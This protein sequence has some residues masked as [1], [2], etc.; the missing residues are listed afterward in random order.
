MAAGS[1][2]AT[3]SIIVV[4]PQTKEV[5]IASATCLLGL[6]LRSRTP[7]VVVE[8][9]AGVGQS[10]GDATNINR[11]FMRDGL[12]GLVSP[13][14]MLAGLA[15]IDTGHQTR[16]Y[17]I[18][19]TLGE[20][21]TFSGT[22]NGAW[23]GGQTGE[24]AYSVNGVPAGTL[25]YAVQ[26]NVLAGPGVVQAAVNA[27]QS[28]A[29]DLPTR[30][31]A[32]MQ[33]A[34]LGGGDGR[35]SCS[36]D[37]PT[38]CGDPPTNG[39]TNSSYIAFYIVARSGDEDACTPLYATGTSRDVLP[40][41]LL[42]SDLPEIITPQ[43]NPTGMRIYRNISDQG[44]GFGTQP[45]FAAPVV[46]P[47]SSLPTTFATG[48]LF[49]QGGIDLVASLPGTPN[50]LG[51]VANLAGGGFGPPEVF[52]QLADAAT[53]LVGNMDN[54]PDEDIGSFQTT[55]L[56]VQWFRN[57]TLEGG[58]PTF[59]SAGS[60]VLPT[61]ATA[62]VLLRLDGDNMLDLAVLVP[63][64]TQVRLYRRTGDFA[65][66]AATNFT[67]G[68]SASQMQ[69]GDFDGDGDTD[70]ITAHSGPLRLQF[71]RN[72]N[73]VF[74]T[75]A[76][77]PLN[78]TGLGAV[79][80]G[81]L[82][83]DGNADVVATGADRV[84]VLLGSATG[85]SVAGSA[86]Y[87]MPSGVV[88]SFRTMR[89]ADLDGDGD[90][91]LVTRTQ[92]NPN[93]WTI[94]ENAGPPAGQAYGNPG[95]F[96]N[97]DGCASGT[98][99]QNYNIIT[100]QLPAADPVATMQQQF[101]A[102]RAG[103]VGVPD[104]ILSTAIVPEP[105]VAGGGDRSIQVQLRDHTGVAVQIPPGTVARFDR[106]GGPALIVMQAPIYSPAL[107]VISL[108]F[109]PVAAGTQTIRITIEVPGRR[110][111]VLMPRTVV[112]VQPFGGSCDSID[113]NN[114]GSFFDPIDVDA[115]LSVYSEGPCV[116][117]GAMC[118]DVDFNNDGQFFDPCDID[119]FLLAFSEG[120]CTPC[121]Q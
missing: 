69:A 17:G 9:G 87:R 76:D 56:R 84:S 61:G 3:W 99:F 30:L 19:N 39:F 4:N 118:N 68:A 62:P 53:L 92:S 26:G 55:G 65:F 77:L 72:S 47:L 111:I 6:D 71:H 25:A 58:S 21:G 48:F 31:M 70:L 11:T 12:I 97:P 113:F 8:R 2:Q 90:G 37:A 15:L 57:N 43:I 85:L 114:D 107:G 16:Q 86:T 91:D 120:P 13:A 103:L 44:D 88:P 14:D 5:G 24:F 22:Q 45:A 54:D 67:I 73:G 81:D 75:Q 50:R 100:T 101:D 112:T 95:T 29:G 60:L 51:A 115:F 96:L 40:V 82:N 80:V 27:L 28:T 23:A 10:F 121:G 41:Q 46:V 38:S 89:I 110:P 93:A 49:G 63:V 1:A 117:S 59:Q 33:A 36:A 119:S 7:T 83:N 32:A 66:A 102:Q 34:R 104:A 35:C 106:I 42:G 116:P 52:D 109:T 105:A 98:Y 79:G 74:A 18:V 108:P 20:A 64:S 78:L 94:L